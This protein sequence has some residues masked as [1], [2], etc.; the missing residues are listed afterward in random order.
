MV[1]I[2]SNQFTLYGLRDLVFLKHNMN[3]GTRVTDDL[4]RAV[5]YNDTNKRT[6]GCVEKAE[7]LLCR[8]IGD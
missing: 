7:E 2:V 3:M 6:G 1:M 5:M 4:N 8:E